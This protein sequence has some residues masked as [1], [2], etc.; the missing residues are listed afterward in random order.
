M[1]EQVICFSWKTG[2]SLASH[3]GRMEELA[4]GVSM[5]NLGVPGARKPGQE[6][7]GKG[8]CWRKT[9]RDGL[10]LSLPT[11]PG[12]EGAGALS[13]GERSYGRLPGRGALP[14][15]YTWCLILAGI[16]QMPGFTVIPG[17][18]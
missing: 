3:R 11:V 6:E 10:E 14:G 15:R 2:G 1:S 12:G 16:R 8:S 18:P 9:R 5:G 17:D 4:Q 13:V 7:L